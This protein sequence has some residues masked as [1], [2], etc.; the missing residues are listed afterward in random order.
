MKR[1]VMTSFAALLLVATRS[2]AVDQLLSDTD[3]DTSVAR[4]AYTGRHPAVLFDEAHNNFHTSGG[5]YKAFASL[6]TNDGYRVTPN[7]QKF[8]K[9]VFQRY[10][11]LVIANAL[12]GPGQNSP[13]APRS[14]FTAAES[15]AV[16]DWVQSG[17]ALLLITDYPPFGSAAAD[18]AQRLGVDMSKATTFDVANSDGENPSRL[19]F[20]REN[21]LLGDHPIVRGRDDSE[22]VNRVHTFT[23]QSLK[24]PVGSISLLKLADTAVDRPA[25]GDETTSI[26]KGKGK[27]ISAAGRAQGLAFTLGKGRVVVLGEAGMLSA[28]VYGTE[29][30]P[31]GMNVPGNDNRQFALNL[32]H[33]LSNLAAPSSGGGPVASAPGRPQPAPTRPLAAS[34]SAASGTATKPAAPKGRTP[35]GP[36]TP[37]A[38]SAVP[39]R[40]LSTA[41]IVAES[42]PSIALV[43]GSDSF[44]T[45]FLVQP[46]VL[47]TNAHV[48]DDEFISDLEIRFPSAAEGKKGSYPAR[49]LYEDRKRDIALLA[50]KTDLPPLRVAESY[51]FRKG[52][53]ITVIGN[54][55]LGG[56]I[57][58]ENAVSRGVMS[59]RTTLD[60]QDFYQLGIAINP[61]NS[62]GPVFDS[63]GQ[64]IGVATLKSTKQ[65]ALAFCIP[66]DDL[67]AAIEKQAGQSSADTERV[68]SRHRLVTAVKA[69]SGGGALYCLGIDFRRAAGSKAGAGSPQLKETAEK[70]G[71]MI[72]EL[73]KEAFVT[74]AREVALIRKD[75]LVA[76]SVHDKFADLAEN[77][78]RIKTVYDGK[79]SGA[80]ANDA[81]KPMKLTHR[82]LTTSLFETLKLEL[83]EKM[84]VAFD[85]HPVPQPATIT[86]VVPSRPGSLRQRS[87]DRRGR[88]GPGGLRRP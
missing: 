33:W 60:G 47:A 78:G 85:D 40:T 70:L 87:L 76:P 42:E 66:L 1:I 56:E 11:V 29:R 54:P 51:G 13:D 3:F 26:P 38:A 68:A 57:V 24:G 43:K 62:G 22:R 4:P 63:T 73:D 55:G 36:V 5:R 45:G 52:E 65:E 44:G 19:L 72:A 46:G 59:T 30:K 49:L 8:T 14:A 84:L 64:V 10:E 79:R 53:D 27:P 25:A 58:L 86:N 83:P 20:T 82:Q 75:G 77:F 37:Q 7:R 48:I 67:K 34:S 18:L 81:L 9:E 16:H 41:D 69:L 6:M 2:S 35:A 74:L 50:V 21:N 31:L 88:A 61:G 28:Q 39:G 17:G 32:M 15:D 80:A 71:A 12:G 23:G